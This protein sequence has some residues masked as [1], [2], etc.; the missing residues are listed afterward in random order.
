MIFIHP[1]GMCILVND[2]AINLE[3]YISLAIPA[4]K[5]MHK[6]LQ[7]SVRFC[8]LNKVIV[9]GCETKG[10]SRCMWFSG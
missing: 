5:Y 4:V 7:A 1:S 3:G 6:P 9:F 8:K 10:K 2:A